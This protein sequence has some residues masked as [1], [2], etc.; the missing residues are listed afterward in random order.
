MRPADDLVLILVAF[1]ISSI[2]SCAKNLHLGDCLSKLKHSAGSNEELR[3]TRCT[4]TI[5]N[6]HV[7]FIALYI[8]ICITFF[9]S[10]SDFVK[11]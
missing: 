4:G 11:E 8:L 3:P 1:G 7:A 6:A 9:F 10:V 2:H 5:F